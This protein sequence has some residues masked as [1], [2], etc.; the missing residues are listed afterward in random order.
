MTKHLNN[1][2]GI[3]RNGKK[4]MC[5]CWYCNLIDGRGILD[6]Y[7]CCRRCGTNLRRY[8]N[9]KDHPCPDLGQPHEYETLG[10][11]ER[12]MLP[13]EEAKTEQEEW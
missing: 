11:R 3:V 2:Q 5:Y 10:H 13:D 6:E 9:R 1:R 8:P 7:G 4:K 12:F